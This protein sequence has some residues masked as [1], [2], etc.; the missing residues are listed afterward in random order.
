M[1]S[2]SNSYLGGSNSARPGQPS[3]FAPQQPQ[4]QQPGAPYGQQ[5]GYG[6]QQQQQQ[7]QPMY[8][9]PT[10]YGAPLQSQF[11]G[12]P[13]QPLQQQ[14]TAQ[15]LLPLQQQP[16][17]QYQQYGA[18]QQPQFQQPMQQQLPQPT[19]YQQQQQPQQPQPTGFQPQPPTQQTPTHAIQPPPP[20]SASRQAPQPTGMTSAQMADSF[21][22]SSSSSSKPAPAATRSSKI[23]NIRL[24]FITASDQAKFEQLFKSA[25]ADGQAMTGD[26]ARELLMRSKLTGDALAHIWTLSDTTKSGQLLFPEF[27]LAM[28]LCNLKL[29][30]KEMPPSLPER[31]RNEVSSMVDIISFGIPDEKPLPAIQGNAPNFFDSRE[32]NRSPP[33]IQQPQPQVSNQQI[34]AGLSSQPTGMMQQQ[35]T[36]YPGQSGMPQQ[37]TGMP[38]QPTG[39]QPQQTAYTGMPQATGYNGPRPPIP[40][41]PTGYGAGPVAPLNAQPTGA[42]G[43]WGL[44]N[45]PASGL[46]NIDALHSQMMPQTGREGGWSSAGLSGNAT[47]PWAVTKDEKKIYDDIFKAWDGFGKGYVSGDQAIEIFGQSGLAKDDLMK[48]WTLSDVN[49]KGRLNL[50]EFAVAMHLIYRKLNGYP[51]PNRLPPELTPPSTRNLNDSIGTVKSMLQR[52]AE[53][54]KNTG[55]FLQPQ[56]TGVSYLKS[57]SFRQGSPLDG[58]ADGTVFKNDDDHVG[59]RSSARRRMGADGRT[60]SPAPGSPNSDTELSGDQLRKLIK[61]KQILLDAI[62]FNDEN[63]AEEDETL[64]RR[65]RRDADE[66][67]RRIRRAQEELDNHPNA[68][69]ASS[70]G[71]DAERRQLSRQLQTMNDRLPDLASQVRRCER[72]IADAQLE[73]FRLKDA[74]AHPGSA[75]LVGTGPGGTVTEN[76]RLRARAKALMQQRSAA[77]TGKAAPATGDDP[78]AAAQ[79]LEA[80]SQ[81]VRDEREKNE[82]MV[83]DVEEGVSTFGKSLQ[84]SL[85]DGAPSSSADHERRRWEDGLGVEEEV[86][87][88]IFELQRSSES[89]KSRKPAARDSRPSPVENRSTSFATSAPPAAT[90]P[91]AASSGAAPSYASYRTAEER[92]A[93]IKQQAEQRMAER[94]AALG[95]KPTKVGETPQQRAER[96][97]K[98]QEEKRQR[99]E[100]EDAQREQ[101]RQRRLA[102]ETIA[103]PSVGKQAKKPPPPPTRKGGSHTTAPA[104]VESKRAVEQEIREEQVAQEAETKRLENEERHQEDELAREKEAQESRLRALE[105]QVRQGKLKK[106]EE[107]KRRQAEKK[108]EKERETRLAAQKAEIEAAKERERQLQLQLEGLG[109]DDDSSSDDDAPQELTPTGTNPTASQELTPPAQPAIPVS[110]P[111]APPLPASEAP[112]PPRSTSSTQPSITPSVDTETKNPFLKKM[113]AESAATVPTIPPVSVQPPSESTNPFHRL[114]QQESKSTP[115]D[116]SP[117]ATRAAR[118][119]ARDDDDWSVVDESSSDEEDAPIGGGAKQLASLL[120]GTMAPPRPLSA[121]DSKSPTSPP[122]PPSSAPPP[123]GSGP[124]PPPP[125][126]SSGAPPPPPLPSGGPPPPPPM[127]APSGPPAGGVGRGA[128][129]AGITAG[130]GLKKVQTKDRSTSATAGRVLD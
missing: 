88:F 31:V 10:G 41:M 33:V 89:A 80:E 119:K 44:V 11:T 121:M 36:G 125:L 56:R 21:R 70:G 124:P 98:E 123:P 69:K 26:Q 55:A 53:H 66:L 22:G 117:T 29:N 129:L 79:R 111:P 81:R 82:R 5:P 83:K 127:P 7:Q 108:A 28:Y 15:P 40:P 60:P 63:Q 50:D 75:P 57:K 77:L 128:L 23:P 101:E 30:G 25:V 102:D 68:S 34:L 105:E 94:L 86:R 130:V 122:P 118:L 45:A 126:P 73:L 72:A 9:Q 6:Q 58:K 24:S 71:S 110:I 19:G 48:V 76:D 115:G 87:D 93:Y 46:P 100:A 20:N 99:A 13:Q 113:Q 84:D 52:D 78:A 92:A 4:Q 103:P 39:L 8:G 65:D 42:P 35:F 104:P 109:D 14:Q 64:D 116:T 51:V 114:A 17:Q 91:P 2:G 49:D 27:A 1:F 18:Q 96:E 47:I 67:F 3:P 59:Y 107:K 95:I 16:T 61:E 106:E 74:K 54:R 37:P 12:Y 120:F 112:S 62:D 85:K 97:R 32:S 38:M 43:Q 90:P